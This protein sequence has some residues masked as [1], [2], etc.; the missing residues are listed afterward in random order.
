MD[1]SAGLMIVKLCLFYEG[2]NLF[3]DI[4]PCQCSDILLILLK[5]AFDLIHFQRTFRRITKL[6]GSLQAKVADFRIFIPH[7]IKPA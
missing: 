6:L 7:L 5:A 1:I 4:R 2:D 3:S